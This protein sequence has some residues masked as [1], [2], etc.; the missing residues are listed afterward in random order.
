MK[1]NNRWA[2]YLGGTFILVGLLV[3]FG[4]VPLPYGNLGQSAAKGAMLY[5]ENCASCHGD[6]LEGQADWQTKNSDGIL[7]A[8]PHDDSGHTWHHA[9]RL[10]FDY[11]KLGGR[12]ALAQS[13]VPDFKSGMPG[14]A[15]TMTDPDIETVLAF[16][17]S[18]WPE[19]IQ[20]IQQ[21]RTWA[22]EKTF[23]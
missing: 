20:L 13:G 23:K 4:L 19:D 7:P 6:N 2:L 14:F 22:A 15:E 8:P 16:I 12:A 1:S 17:K 18:K 11:V 5:V 9:D 21:K 3:T 10:L